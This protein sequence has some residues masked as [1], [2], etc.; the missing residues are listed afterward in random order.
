MSEETK[1]ATPDWHARAQTLDLPTRALVDGQLREASDGA[2]FQRI[3]P[4]T[5][6][7]LVEV[8]ECSAEDVDTAVA[9]ARRTFEQGDWRHASPDERKA[10]MLRWAD[11]IREHADELALLESLEAGKPIANTSSAD[12][13]AC[14]NTIQWYA[15]A[16]DK[17]YDEVAPTGAGNLTTVTREPV[18]VVA[19]VVP[20]NYASIIAS[21]KLGPALAVGNSV[22]LKPAEESPLAA[23][24]LGELALQAGIPAGAVQVLTGRGPVT[25]EAIG[26]HPDIDVVTFTGSAE[27]GKRFLGYSAASNMKRIWLECG[28][29]SPQI[30]TRDCGNLDKAADAIAGSIWYNTGQTCH[31]G[32]RVIVDRKVKDALLERA[33]ARA[34]QFAPGDPLDPATSMGPLIDTDAQAR[35]SEYV[36][37]ARRDGAKVVTGG[38]APG[39]LAQ[40]AFFEPTIVDGLSGD[41][42]IAREEVFGPVL[43]VLTYDDLYEGIRIA[44]DSRYGLA[45][46]VWCDRIDDANRAAAA[47]RAGTVWINCYD[48]SSPVTP[49]GGYKESGI[50][51]DRSLH[52]FDKFTEIKTTW[53]EY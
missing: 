36:D 21:W 30:V 50:G 31:A 41:A 12:I 53:L 19:A 37:G 40:G 25:G 38:Q 9:A 7:L 14:A 29:K 34:G 24:R 44:N 33:A 3:N 16:L 4:A 48:K 18:G 20:W 28:G 13:P 5:G 22:I 26:M 42:R 35:V 8:A 11:L 39:A 51:R 46:S 49:F 52:A 2:K 10:A 1:T 45:A 17:L 15:E 27:I 43:S 23:I 47:L 6:E 32:S